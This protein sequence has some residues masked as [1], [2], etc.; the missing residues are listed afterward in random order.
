MC[1]ANATQVWRKPNTLAVC[2]W[3]STPLFVPAY[4]GPCLSQKPTRFA[5]TAESS[6]DCEECRCS[7]SC[8]MRLSLRMRAADQNQVCNYTFCCTS[9]CAPCLSTAQTGIPKYIVNL[10]QQHV[11]SCLTAN[12]TPLRNILQPCTTV[13]HNYMACK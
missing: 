3:I 13:H 9:C 5:R 4:N 1:T 7:A 8:I 12:S 6:C 11:L 2:H 10:K